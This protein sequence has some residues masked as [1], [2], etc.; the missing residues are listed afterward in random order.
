[1][2]IAAPHDSHAQPL[3]D[4]LWDHEVSETSEL[5]G[6]IVKGLMSLETS[7]PSQ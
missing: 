2:V 6:G 1:M 7:N 4:P 5:N 3:L